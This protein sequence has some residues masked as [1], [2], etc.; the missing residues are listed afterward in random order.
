[1][2]LLTYVSVSEHQIHAIHFA[3]IYMVF[4][5]AQHKDVL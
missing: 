5:K 1:M 4:N 2:R 3:A